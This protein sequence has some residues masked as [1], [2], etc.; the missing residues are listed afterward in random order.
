MFDYK[1]HEKNIKELINDIDS[2]IIEVV[3]FA[4]KITKNLEVRINK[5]ESFKNILD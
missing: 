1:K 5:K 2:D 4:N 3:I